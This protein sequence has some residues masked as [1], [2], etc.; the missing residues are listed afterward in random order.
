MS[1]SIRLALAL[2][3]LLLLVASPVGAAGEEEVLQGQLEALNIGE[4]EEYL[5]QMQ[6]ELG[7]YL[8]ELSFAD[9]LATLRGETGRLDFV[10]FFQGL[11]RYLFREIIASS[12]ILGKL[13][14]LAVLSAILQNLQNAFENETIANLAHTVCYLLLVMVAISSFSVAITTGKEIIDSLVGFMQALLPLLLTLLA[15]LGGITSVALLQ[16]ALIF[17][18]NLIGMLI[19][20]IVFPAL[21]FAAVLDI[22]GNISEQFK[23]S[24]FSAL[25][26]DFSVSALGLSLVGFVGIISV[27]GVAG[28]VADGVGLRTA[29]YLTGTFVPVVG[30]I[31][32]DAVEVVVGCSLILKNAVGIFGVIMIFLLAAFPLVKIISLIVIYRVAGALLQPLGSQRIADCLHG[33]GNS[34]TLVFGAVATVGLMFFIAVT[35]IVGAGNITVMLR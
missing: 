11:G 29:K 3:V 35:M 23:V 13:I 22:V 2:A 14:V 24:R 28:T 15:A 33:M 12:S 34:L 31:F 16:P 5:R 1:R 19:K 30:K 17:A 7:G 20:T 32:A 18:V 6:Q 25:L 10:A 27:Q 26:R 9:I 21:F 8:P 4:V